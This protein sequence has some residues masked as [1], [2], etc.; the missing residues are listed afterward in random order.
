M[1]ATTGSSALGGADSLDGGGGW[2]WVSYGDSDEG[3]S[4][5]LATGAGFGGHAQGDTIS[6]FEGVQ[7]SSHRDVLIGDDGGN[8]IRGLG[9][10]D[11][12]DGGGG[13]D[14]GGLPGF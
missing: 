8:L 3:V 1:A 7:G 13:S 4:V 2:D 10:A 5:N 11:S 9:G 14:W 6:N 12:L